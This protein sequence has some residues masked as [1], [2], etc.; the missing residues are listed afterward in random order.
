M[1]DTSK[2]S[3]VC[4]VPARSQSMDI[5]RSQSGQLGDK[6]STALNKLTSRVRVRK[7]SFGYGGVPGIGRVAERSSMVGFMN[8]NYEFLN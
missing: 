6:S 3:K 8:V 4:I 7:S 2:K 1:A 5:K